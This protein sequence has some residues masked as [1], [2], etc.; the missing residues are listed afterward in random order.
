M[1]KTESLSQLRRNIIEKLCID[2]WLDVWFFPELDG[3]KGWRGSAPI[4]FV[5]LNPST[6]NFPSK[7][8]RL[9][10]DSLSQ[11]GLSD[12]HITDLLKIRLDGESVQE[13]F[14][15]PELVQSHKAWLMEEVRL[16]EPHI[17]VA[18]G[19]KTLKV[20]TTW[21]PEDFRSRIVKIH[22]YS[23]AQR[24]KKNDVFAHDIA[25]IRNMYLESIRL[26]P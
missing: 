6:G 24:W 17:I 22:H 1:S 7:A 14:A 23:W 26:Y 3:V 2:Q 25:S 19:H 13:T 15:I 10:Y 4:M 11:N 12:A 5:G 20:L 16:L 9:F 21:L 18:L 8:D